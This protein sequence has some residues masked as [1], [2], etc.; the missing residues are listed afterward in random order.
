MCVVNYLVALLFLC[1]FPT[2]HSFLYNKPQNK[3]CHT[4]IQMTNGNNKWQLN[5]F[6]EIMLTRQLNNSVIRIHTELV[7]GTS[8]CN[9]C[10][11]LIRCKSNISSWKQTLIADIDGHSWLPGIPRNTQVPNK[12][13][14]FL[15][16]TVVWFGKSIFELK[17]FE[18]SQ[19][20]P[21][22]HAAHQHP[23]AA[24]FCTSQSSYSCDLLPA[25]SRG[26]SMP[27]RS[28]EQPASREQLQP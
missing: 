20:A 23:N 2:C 10:A 15:L 8:C 16:G 22:H 6:K 21:A 14:F 17:A 28:T 24:N 26:C 9:V 7:K 25:Y 5:Q 18:A 4:G 13:G 12:S 1:Y 3:P 19:Q 11:H 27:R